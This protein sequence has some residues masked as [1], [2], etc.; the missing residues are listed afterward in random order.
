[1]TKEEIRAEAYVW[2][3]KFKLHKAKDQHKLKEFF[4]KHDDAEAKVLL[5]N[6]N[7]KGELSEMIKANRLINRQ[8]ILD[9]VLQWPN[10]PIPTVVATQ[11]PLFIP[12]PPPKPGKFIYC[13]GFTI[14]RNPSPFGGGYTVISEDHKVLE[15]VEVQKSGFTNNEGELLGIE[16]AARHAE[17]HDRIITDS[18]CARGWALKGRAGARPDLNILAKKARYLITQKSLQVIW[19]GRE[20]NLAGIYNEDM[21]SKQF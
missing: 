11:Q 15:H 19:Q 6:R 14:N 16:A 18:Q 3:R 17:P 5:K 21:V 10:G 1:M 9:W 12:P 13:D 8:E 7:L 2:L 20:T 4:L